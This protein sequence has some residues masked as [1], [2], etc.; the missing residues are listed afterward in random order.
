[1]SSIKTATPDSYSI[2]RFFDSIAFRYDAMNHVLSFKLD[3][4]WRK[5][6]RDL[7]V[8]GHEESVLDLGIGTGKFLASFCELKK[9]KKIAGLDF[10]SQ[11]LESSKQILPKEVE[12]VHGD[13]KD[14]PFQPNSFDLVISAFTLRSVQSLAPFFRQIH[15]FLKPRGKVGFLCLTRPTSFLWK[16]LYYPYLMIYLPLIGGL[17]S[18]NRDAYRFLSAS[19][20]HFQAPEKTAEMLRETGFQKTEIHR[21]TFGT[22]T[23]IIGEK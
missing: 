1:M 15:S 2:R 6:S 8:S 5:K 12:L 9:W 20:L 18:G 23:L 14:M 7:L 16:L 22:A 10:S 13:F 19:I 4:L 3:D 21:F 11:M 17:F